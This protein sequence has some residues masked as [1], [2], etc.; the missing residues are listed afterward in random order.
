M[1]QST[2]IISIDTLIKTVRKLKKDGK[3]IVHCHGVF[4]LLHP[5]HI[6]Y[7]K[8]AKALGDILIVSISADKFVNKGATR[9]VFNENLRA[10]VLS[11]IETI[12]YIV[13]VLAKDAVSLIE[14][15]QPHVFVI[16]ADNNK[17]R[18][19]LTTATAPLPEEAAVALY[20]GLVHFADD[21]IF[22]SSHLINQYLNIYPLPTK[23]YLDDFRQ[24]YTAEEIIAYLRQIKRL[25]ILVI[26][27]S[28]IDEYHY[29]NTLG[30]SS[31]EPLVVYQFK[32]AEAFAGATLA[33]ANHLSTLTDTVELVSLLG[34][35]QTFEKFIGTNLDKHITTKFFYHPRANTTV[36][37]RYLDVATKQKLFQVSFINDQE[38][39]QTVESKV[40]EYLKSIINRYDLV[41]VNDFGH[42]FLTSRLIKLICKKAKFLALNVQANSANYGFNVITKY[43]RADYVCIDEHEIRLAT[44]NKYASINDLI[45]LMYRK[46]KCKQM[47]VTRGAFGSI[48][49]STRHVFFETPALSNRVI[50]RVGA[51]DAL[52]AITAPCVYLGLP[53]EIVG[54]IGNVAGAM[55]V[56]TLGNKYTLQFP[57]IANYITYLLK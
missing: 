12:D 11:A 29:C 31:K 20:G 32:S 53:E 24:K 4:E 14:K 3:K 30:K 19:K 56:Q 52:F 44:H 55:K 50:D 46:L 16:G 15:L 34:E 8:T 13:I 25:K 37:R 36:T 39:D 35:K 42:G 41:V 21:I 2:K 1:S 10:E 45:K 57:E 47:L 26:G 54:F 51:G 17:K 38:I 5:G 40:S 7:F 28:K 49:Y 33:T 48:G 27:D 23:K 22:S 9:P 6:R 18:T 43:P